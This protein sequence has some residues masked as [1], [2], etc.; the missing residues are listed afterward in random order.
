L[1]LVPLVHLPVVPPCGVLFISIY[2]RKSK[3]TQGRRKG[4]ARRGER[5]NYLRETTNPSYKDIFLI[6]LPKDDTTIWR[7]LSIYE[8]SF[9]HFFGFY[10]S[11]PSC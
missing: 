11:P 9:F 4:L 7:E 6:F 2:D 3:E 10:F 5:K 8:S 1:A